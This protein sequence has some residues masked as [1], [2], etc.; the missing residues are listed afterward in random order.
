MWLTIRSIQHIIVTWEESKSGSVKTALATT[1][2]IE[3]PIKTTEVGGDPFLVL[4]SE[5]IWRIF[6]TARAVKEDWS[7]RTLHL[8]SWR[9]AYSSFHFSCF[10]GCQEN[11][12]MQ[13][14]AVIHGAQRCS[15]RSILTAHTIHNAFTVEMYTRYYLTITGLHILCT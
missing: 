3:W 12:F 10:S 9:P 2:P 11:P 13:K 1:P 8:L 15:I 5:Y 4:E 7:S 14:D 6:L